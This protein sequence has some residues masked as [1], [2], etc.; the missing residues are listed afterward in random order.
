MAS[1]CDY[2]VTPFPW[3][4]ELLKEQG[5]QVSFWGH[6]LAEM[7]EKAP[8]AAMLTGIALLP[9]S[10]MHEVQQN[11]PLIAA[12]AKRLEGPFRFAVAQTLDKAELE[13]RWKKL[14]GPE[15][16]YEGSVHEILKASR[17]AIV[18][19]GT[20]TLEA[21]LCLCPCVV[22]YKLSRMMTVE[23]AI[24]SPKFDFISFPNILAPALRLC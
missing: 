6:P 18:C 5:A 20:A 1:I 16:T 14:G 7:V 2:I 15:A 21:A 3:S 17:A 4:A 11:L 24:V 22:L 8:D 12:A 9:G 13:R 10:R 23:A 19:S